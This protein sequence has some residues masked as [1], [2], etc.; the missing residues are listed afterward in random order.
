MKISRLVRSIEFSS[1]FTIDFFY[2]W[3]AIQRLRVEWSTLL[4]F[5]PFWLSWFELNEKHIRRIKWHFIQNL[6]RL[7][8]MNNSSNWN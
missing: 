1:F 7:I 2:H 4:I 5:V 8:V 3:T 6:A